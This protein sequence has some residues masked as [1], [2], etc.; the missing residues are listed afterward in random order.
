MIVYSKQGFLVKSDCLKQMIFNYKCHGTFPFR[1]DHIDPSMAFLGRAVNLSY[2]F[3][4]LSVFLASASCQSLGFKKK[5]AFEFL[6]QANK[7]LKEKGHLS[8]LTSW[9]HANFITQDTIQIASQS[10]ARFSALA[11]QM[12]LE[13]KKYQGRNKEQKRMLDIL[14]RILTVPSPEDPIK[15]KELSLLKT[16][17]ESLYGSGQYCKKKCQSLEDLEKVMAESRN[18]RELLDAWNGW[19]KISIPM[20]SKYKRSVELGN[21]GARELGYKNMADLWR[22]NYDMSPQS[23]EKELDR[24]WIEVKPFYEQLHC[25]V[26]HKLNKK[27]GRSV[28]NLKSPIPAHLLGNMW[29]QS[30]ENIGDIVGVRDSTNITKLIKRAKY[31]SKKMVQT[32]ENFFVSLGM[33]KL[34]KSF[35]KNSLFEKPRD[36]E[37]VCHAS[38]W[39][40]D[41][42]DDVR[43]KMCIKIN[44]ENFRTI[45]HELGHIYYY[46][47][48]KDL[49]FIYQTSANDGFHE[50]LGDTIELSITGEYLKKIRLLKGKTRKADI[51]K[52]LKLALSKIAFLPFGLMVD[53]YRW[54]VFDGRTSPKDYNK[55]WWKLREKYQGIKAPNK[56]PD[57][58][59]DP[60]AKYHIP[61]YTPYSRYFLAHILQFQFHRSLCKTSGH[62]GPLHECSIFKSKKAGQKLWKMMKMGASQPWFEA[63]KVITGSQKMDASAIRDYFAPLEKWLK[64]KN[65]DLKCGW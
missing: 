37:V 62:K 39:H 53:K 47:A 36:R 54:Q 24:L 7:N 35:Y 56:R 17:L 22:S 46:L 2:L 45:H 33:P 9:V 42:R 61:G 12:A 6:N 64:K 38:A 51:H 23:F 21:L 16:E 28:V 29:A 14:G 60:G 65:K 19:R 40:M 41:S 1:K 20:T 52:L 31:D 26:R 32:A 5:G 50:A 8:S 10:N 27:Y 3:L 58:A 43:I 44:E 59:F 49:P 25:F 11:T 55:H 4:C 48:Y 57:D 15:N 18:P 63:L 13:S 34:P 30:W